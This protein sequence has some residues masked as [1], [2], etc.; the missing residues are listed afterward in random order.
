MRRPRTAEPRL[1]RSKLVSETPIAAEPSRI[2]IAMRCASSF[3]R[4]DTDT[5]PGIICSPPARSNCEESPATDA[6]RMSDFPPVLARAA[7]WSRTMDR[8]PYKNAE[9]TARTL[10]HCS[11]QCG[12]LSKSQL[13][14]KAGQ[15]TAV[16]GISLKVR[17]RCS[18]EP[19]AGRERVDLLH[20]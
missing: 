7:L 9:R 19:M 6:R 10:N 16:I 8:Q 3:H 11:S 13:R 14:S 15:R 17:G 5:G 4:H 12:V 18:S 20:L 1:P 2:T